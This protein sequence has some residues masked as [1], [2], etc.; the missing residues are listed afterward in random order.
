[1]CVFMGLLPAKTPRVSEV[2]CCVGCDAPDICMPQSVFHGVVVL[3]CLL[4]QHHMVHAVTRWWQ[5]LR[6]RPSSTSV[7]CC[8]TLPL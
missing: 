6:P 4:L 1:M 2:I 3:W 8:R 5:V 7:C